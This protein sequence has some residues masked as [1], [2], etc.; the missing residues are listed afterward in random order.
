MSEYAKGDGMSEAK[1]TS[2]PW[3]VHGTNETG[4]LIASDAAEHENI[5]ASI[6]VAQPR[7][8]EWTKEEEANARLIAAAPEL[9]AA[10]ESVCNWADMF[11]DSLAYESGRSQIDAARAAIQKATGA[12]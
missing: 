10:L 7:G 8:E 5:T 2:G 11:R 9:L 6:A 12:A 3:N 4:T 1:H